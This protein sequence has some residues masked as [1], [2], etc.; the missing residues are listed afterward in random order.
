LCG[1]VP[2][3]NDEIDPKTIY[4]VDPSYAQA[5]LRPDVVCGLV[6]AMLVCVARAS[7]TPL[8]LHLERSVSGN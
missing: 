8:R 6:D 7:D 4:I 5:F 3:P 1:R 2:N